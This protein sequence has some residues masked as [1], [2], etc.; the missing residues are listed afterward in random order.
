MASTRG[1]QAAKRAEVAKRRDA[2][3]R[4]RNDGKQYP[5]IAEALGYKTPAAACQD[6]SRALEAHLTELAES[7]EILRERELQRLDELYEVAIAVLRRQHL[8][9]S[10]GKVVRIGEPDV[11]DEG[12]AFIAE[13]RGELV[14]DDGPALAAIDRC[15]KIEESRRKL[16]GLDSPAKVETT[17]AVS[18]RIEG[19]DLADLG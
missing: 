12:Q 6:V 9:I 14:L 13:G 4:M 19:V 5:E 2:A 15:V 7:V 16:L 17:G 1:T 10:N 18:F 8:T 3:V 11:D